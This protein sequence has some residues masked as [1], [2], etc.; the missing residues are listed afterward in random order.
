MTYAFE[1]PRAEGLLKILW[2][3]V[4]SVGSVGSAGSDGS[5]GSA[6][7]DGAA[8]RAVTIL[9][10]QSCEQ[11]SSQSRLTPEIKILACEALRHQIGATLR[12]NMES[13]ESVESVGSDE[14]FGAFGALGTNGTRSQLFSG[15]DSS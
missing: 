15:K 7:S 5:D 12:E 8:L 4:G 6:G 9:I 2:K 14:A 1:S 11:S 13:V 3:I 10:S